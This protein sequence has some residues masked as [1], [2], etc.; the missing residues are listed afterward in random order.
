M[1]LCFGSR[2]SFSREQVKEIAYGLER[3]GQRFLWV[4]KIPPM[5]N[6]SKEIKQEN[7]VWNGLIWMSLCQKG[8]WKEPIIEEWW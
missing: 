6:K 7:L 2:G 1:F 8:S 4:V 5:D 3:S